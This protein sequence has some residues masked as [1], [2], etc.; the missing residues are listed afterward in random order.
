MVIALMEQGVNLF[1]KSKNS[2]SYNRSVDSL[3][4]RFSYQK[5]IEELSNSPLNKMIE[6]SLQDQIVKRYVYFYI[7]IFL[8]LGQG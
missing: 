5:T 3:S 8:I 2:Y 6:I 7:T 4:P 1:I